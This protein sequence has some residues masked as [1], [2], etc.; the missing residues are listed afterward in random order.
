VSARAYC[1]AFSKDPSPCPLTRERC[2]ERHIH[3]ARED[4]AP[5]KRGTRRTP[6]RRGWVYGVIDDLERSAAGFEAGAITAEEFREDVRRHCERLQRL[7]KDD[8][9]QKDDAG[10][11]EP[12]EPRS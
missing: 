6:K 3:H 1:P 10:N 8:D 12:R 4:D 2:A 5:P 9:L 7:A 11:P